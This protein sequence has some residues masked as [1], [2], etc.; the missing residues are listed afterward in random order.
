[1]NTETWIP[2]G[3]AIHNIVVGQQLEITTSREGETYVRASPHQVDDA[4][5]VA[6]SQIGALKDSIKQRFLRVRAQEMIAKD[7]EVV[8][9]VNAKICYTF[10][11]YGSRESMTNNEATEAVVAAV[12]KVTG[13]DPVNH[14]AHY[15]SGKI[16]VIEAIEDWKLNYHLGQVIKYVARAGK[17]DPTKIIEDLQ[18]A[19]WYLKRE[20]SKHT[21]IS[22]S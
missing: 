20:I 9:D 21:T 3:L 6:V 10:L 4:A 13:H 7:D 8:V 15:T 1:M 16:E 2:C 22:H 11:R 12:Q 17:K 14:P 18:K 19:E 5:P